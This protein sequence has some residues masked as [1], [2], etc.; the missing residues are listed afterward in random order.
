[1]ES[2]NNGYAVSREKLLEHSRN[3]SKKARESYSRNP[4]HCPECGD[5]LP[6]EKRT[7]VYKFCS[8]SCAA[9]YSNKR[10]K[11]PKRSLVCLQCG[12]GL[13][14]K[15]GNKFCSRIC[16]EA[17]NSILAQIEYEEFIQRWLCGNESGAIADGSTNRKIRR[18]FMEKHDGKCSE[19]GWSRVNPT[20][21][22]IPLALDHI[23]GDSKNNKPDNLRLLCPNCH[24]LTPTYGS[25]N[26]GRGRLDRRTKAGKAKMTG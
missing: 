13:V 11:S 15:A 20:T 4:K 9:T 5:A 23:D 22:T 6:Y 12:S 19:C 16:Q 24:S 10:R 3:S 17:Y 8:S 25:L 26:N 21:G 2:K 18:W 7:K 14:G 1:M